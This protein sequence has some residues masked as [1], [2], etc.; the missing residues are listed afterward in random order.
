MVDPLLPFI[1]KQEA[2]NGNGKLAIATHQKATCFKL[3]KCH[4]NLSSQ[5][6]TQNAPNLP[7]Y[8]ALKNVRPHVANKTFWYIFSCPSY[9]LPPSKAVKMSVLATILVVSNKKT[10]HKWLIKNWA[11]LG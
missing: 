11:D 7:I 4:T 10:H 1:K 8:K 9:Y 2:P 3:R 6:N 5:D